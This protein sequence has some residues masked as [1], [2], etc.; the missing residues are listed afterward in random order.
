MAVRQIT[1]IIGELVAKLDF[2]IVITSNTDNGGGNHVLEC[3]NTYYLTK[4]KVILID[5]FPYEVTDFD[6][7]ISFTV[8][9]LGHTNPV[10]VSTFNLPA[11]L[12]FFGSVISTD[13]EIKRTM[14]AADGT[15]PIVYL[16]ENIKETFFLDRTLQ[17]E[18]DS[19]IQ[20]FFLDVS[21]YRDNLN[22]DFKNEVLKPLS[23]LEAKF[24]EVLRS[25]KGIGKLTNEYQRMNLARFARTNQDGET[26]LIF[27]EEL[28]GIEIDITIPIKKC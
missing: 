28:T 4:K 25:S 10:T 3:D 13:I 17:Y 22:E 19:P 18:R 21:N 11:P 2:D 27:S 20:L 8:K 14:E 26:D 6:F 24:F 5:S 15:Y 23:N 9:P 1:D 12:Y 7:N 16:F